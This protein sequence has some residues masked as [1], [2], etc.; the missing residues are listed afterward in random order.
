M[1]YNNNREEGVVEDTLGKGP[2]QRDAQ[3]CDAI[4]SS[5]PCNALRAPERHTARKSLTTILKKEI[6]F[7][8]TKTRLI[9]KG[10]CYL[11]ITCAAS[12]S[13]DGA[14]GSAPGGSLSAALA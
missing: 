12:R 14:L 4:C 7:S 6:L 1:E 5:R 9:P 8:L 3:Q 11:L 13:L 10:R 2:T